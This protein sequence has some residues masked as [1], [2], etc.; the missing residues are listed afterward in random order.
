MR[1]PDYDYLAVHGLRRASLACTRDP[2]RKAEEEPTPCGA[3]T[4][5]LGF[6]IVDRDGPMPPKDSQTALLLTHDPAAP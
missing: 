3:D 1:I 6:S 4:L 5:H 2:A